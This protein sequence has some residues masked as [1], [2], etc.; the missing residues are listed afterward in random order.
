MLTRMKLARSTK[1]S[2]VAPSRKPA[3]TYGLSGMSQSLVAKT[4]SAASTP[5]QNV[6]RTR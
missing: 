4:A 2:T 5:P 3:N 1:P 6:P